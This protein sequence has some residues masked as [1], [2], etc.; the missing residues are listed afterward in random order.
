MLGA[1]I[2]LL[3]LGWAVNVPYYFGT[4]FY[5][6]QFLATVLGL[7]LALAFNAARLARQAA[8]EILAC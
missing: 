2:T 3:C 8:R 1:T 6:E 5:Q 4:A 7:A